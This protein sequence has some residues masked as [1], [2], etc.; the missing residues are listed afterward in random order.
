MDPLPISEQ[1]VTVTLGEVRK[2][3][4]EMITVARALWGFAQRERDRH[5]AAMLY[6]IAFKPGGMLDL[7]QK[8][9]GGQAT[10]E[11]FDDLDRL[12]KTSEQRVQRNLVKLN[13][14]SRTFREKF[15]FDAAI[16]LEGNYSQKHYIREEIRK[17][18]ES[19]KN[20]GYY[21]E[22]YIEERANSLIDHILFINNSLRGAHEIIL[23]HKGGKNTS[24]TLTRKAG[25]KRP[26]TTKPAQHA[27]DGLSDLS[28]KR[29]GR[30]SKE[31][32]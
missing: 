5:A 9:K 11:T 31:I 7:L 23:F 1:M 2:A 20:S 10:P 13:K 18:V 17:L 4:R 14:Y 21:E 24:S 15:G 32:L 25:S 16:A 6:G 3:A 27:V 22:G 8:I 29:R 30:P 12:L 26:K 28:P 19:S